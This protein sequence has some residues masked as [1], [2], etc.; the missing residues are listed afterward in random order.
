MYNLDL[1][2]LISTL[3][4]C[5]GRKKATLQHI[6]ERSSVTLPTLKRINSKK[7]VN[8]T[9]ETVFSILNYFLKEFRE[10]VPKTYS[11]KELFISLF[12]SFVLIEIPSTKSYGETF[13]AQGD[14]IDVLLKD[15]FKKMVG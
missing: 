10:Y 5:N 8:V 14:L 13:M 11:D 15:H 3:K 6:S 1:K 12:L 2:N 7:N 9:L 4:L